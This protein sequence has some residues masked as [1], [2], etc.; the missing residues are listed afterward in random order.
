MKSQTDWMEANLRLVN[1][2]L[3]AHQQQM[4]DTEYLSNILFIIFI[5]RISRQNQVAEGSHIWWPQ[6]LISVLFLVF[7]IMWYIAGCAATCLKPWSS[8]RKGAHSRSKPQIEELKYLVYEWGKK[9]KVDWQTNLGCSCSEA[10]AALVQWVIGEKSKAA[11]LP[12]LSPMITNF[13][14]HWKNEIVDT[15][16]GNELSP[17]GRVPPH[18]HSDSGKNASW[19]RF[20]WHVLSGGGP[21]V[22]V[23]MDGWMNR[24]SKYNQQLFTPQL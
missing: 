1:C 22:N 17:K 20:S 9:D 18:H 3:I 19:V 10:V 2:K 11:H 15:S 13:D 4:H 7:W 12:L 6:N 23:G 14:N 8:G 16:F 24:L 5:D 21:R